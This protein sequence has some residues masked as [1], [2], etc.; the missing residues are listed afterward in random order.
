MPIRLFRMDSE[1]KVL[2]ICQRDDPD[3]GGA[4]RV[5]ESLVREQRAAGLEVWILFLYGPPGDLA[6]RFAPHVQCLG[7]ASSRQAWQGSVTLHRQIQKIQPDCIHSHDGLLW[8]RLNYLLCRIP[9][10]TH[11]HAPPGNMDVL[12]NRLA[13]RLTQLTTDLLIGISQHTIDAWV[14]AGYPDRNIPLIPNGVD[15]AQFEIPDAAKK[16]TLRKQ[17]DLPT[18]KRLVVWV[19]RLH[20]AMKGTDRVELVAAA[21]P[22]DTTLVVVGDGPEFEGIRERSRSSI[23]AGKL[24]LA[25]STYTP[26]NY[27]QAADLYLFTSHLEPFGLVILEAVAC[28]LPL[29]AFPVTEGGGAVE[30][31]REFEATMLEDGAPA[32]AVG[33]AIERGYAKRVDS[34]RLRRQA[35]AAYAWPALSAR[36]VR[37]YEDLLE[38]HA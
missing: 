20:R 35:E 26:R 27:Y 1:M 12:K 37:A 16:K 21:L 33:A 31:L 13:W 34:V 24:I 9:V 15:F 36:V 10:V 4:L 22:E 18:D 6:E 30:L 25:G 23:A 5:A 14:D 32:D 7:I 19:G 8:P 38:G 2:H 29:I 28:G 11:A 3:T 17:L